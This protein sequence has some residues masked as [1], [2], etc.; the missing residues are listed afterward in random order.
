LKALVFTGRNEFVIEDRDI[1]EIGPFEVLVKVNFAGLCGTD[2]HILSGDLQSEFPII[3]CHEF[4][5]VV[6]DTGSE[7]TN[8]QKGDKVVV[9]PVLSCG[10]CDYCLNGMENYCES[11]KCYGGSLDGGFSEYTRVHENNACKLDSKIDLREAVLLEPLACALYGISK[12]EIDMGD[13]ALIFGMGTMGLLM[14]QLLRNKGVSRVAMVD[15]NT[16]KFKK[17]ESLGACRA[18]LNDGMLDDRLKDIS[19]RGFDILIDATGVREVCQQVFKY[20]TVNSRILLYGVCK[21]EDEINIK[22]HTLYRNDLSV[23]GAFSFSRDK[24]LSAIKIL[25]NNMVDLKNLISHE[26]RVEEFK[27]SLEILK[28]GEAVKIIFDLND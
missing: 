28:S 16:K 27:K 24:L 26:L 22:P 2:L 25:S 1:P 7:V 8:L 14:L 13:T 21:P 19:P 23:Y 18:L 11:F 5:G 15:V 17:A 12:I 4:S 20:F 3:P 6:A 10:T 9:N